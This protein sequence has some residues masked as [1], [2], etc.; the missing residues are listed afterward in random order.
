VLAG[1]AGFQSSGS[2]YFSGTPGFMSPADGMLAAAF[3]GG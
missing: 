2:S 1:R 3:K